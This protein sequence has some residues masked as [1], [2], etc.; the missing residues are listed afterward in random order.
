MNFIYIIILNEGSPDCHIKQTD[1]YE[2]A[3]EIYKEHLGYGANPILACRIKLIG[4]GEKLER[5][6]LTY[7]EATDRINIDWNFLAEHAKK[8]LK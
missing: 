3:L 5:P 2:E 4:E 7:D 8:H 6:L 1:S